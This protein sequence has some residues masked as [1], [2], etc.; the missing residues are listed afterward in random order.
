[1]VDIVVSLAIEQRHKIA[2]HKKVFF[3]LVKLVNIREG[4]TDNDD[5]S[6][7]RR[8]GVHGLGRD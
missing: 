7:R 8:V 5:G 6:C 1:M 4:L 3:K 2:I